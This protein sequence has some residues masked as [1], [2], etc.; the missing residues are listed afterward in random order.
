MSPQVSIIVPVYNTGQYVGECIDSIINQSFHDWELLL[1]DDGSTD[2]S[3]Q[4]CGSFACRDNR[5]RYYYKSNG[6]VSSARNFGIDKATGNYIMFVDSDDVCQDN[7]LEMLYNKVSDGFDLSACQITSFSEQTYDCKG[8]DKLYDLNSIYPAFEDLDLL[9][10]P[11]AKL[12]KSKIIKDKAIKFDESLALGE[13][14][15]FNLDYLQFV[16]SAAVVKAPLYNYRDT[17]GSLTKNIRAD[18]ADIQMYLIDRKLQFISQHGLKFSYR[19]Q[20]PGMVRD[21]FLSLCRSN[22][23]TIDKIE[24]IN[25]IKNLKLLQICQKQSSLYDYLLLCSIRYLPASFLIKLFR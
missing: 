10:P 17:P 24:S 25:K 14:L 21:M 9:H 13:D 18:Y 11:Y 7:L 20:A 2:S 8:V 6:G 23:N 19:E 4:I 3:S 15:C 5:I 16:K 1:I 12:Y 22:A